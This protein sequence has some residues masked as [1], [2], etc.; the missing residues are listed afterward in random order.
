MRTRTW[1]ARRVACSAAFVTAAALAGSVLAQQPPG[2]SV[3][4]MTVH[5]GDLNISTPAGATTLYHRILGAARTVC[6]EEGYEI[7][8]DARRFWRGCFHAAVNDAVARVHSP[9]LNAVHRKSNPETPVTAM[10]GH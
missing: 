1:V 4:T 7:G 10:L 2:V 3:K 9:L 5:Y 6:G 8:V